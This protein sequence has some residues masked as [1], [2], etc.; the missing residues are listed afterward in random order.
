MA[1]ARLL[2]IAGFLLAVCAGYAIYGLDPVRR[3]ENVAAVLARSNNPKDLSKAVELDALAVRVDSA[4]P[5]RWAAYGESLAAVGRVGEARGAFQRAVQLGPALPQIWFH[6][7]SFHFAV[8]ERAQGLQS[9]AKILHQVSDYDATFFDYFDHI[10][11]S[12]TEFLP[13][14]EQDRRA[15]RSYMEHLI[16]TGNV[17]GARQAWHTLL[18]RRSLNNQLTAL[19]IELLL[20]S[21]RFETARQDWLQTSQ[22]HDTDSDKENLMSN[23]G[24]ERELTGCALDWVIRPSEQVDTSRDHSVSRDGRWSMKIRFHG[25]SNVSYGNLVQ[26]VIVKPGKYWLKS[27]IRTEGITT[28]Q[29]IGLQLADAEAP[30]RLTVA[31]RSLLGT[32]DWT[33]IEARFT[34][35]EWCHAICI[36]AVRSPSL[37][38]DN[39][40]AGT[41]WLDSVSLRYVS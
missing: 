14:I 23:G 28:D 37:K 12:T 24:F 27:W 17:E 10:H 40:I 25:D 13:Y 1:L 22:S 34:V 30:A 31:T 29:G 5:Y 18:D 39:A 8:S 3:P 4:N 26:T 11:I 6:D 41:A 16:A 32:N 21:R 9:V 7:A 33:L 36:T 15:T 2:G 20:R 38:F 35:P 19:Y